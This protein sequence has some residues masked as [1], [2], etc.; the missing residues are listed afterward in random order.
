MERTEVARGLARLQWWKITR[1]K[2]KKDKDRD[3]E[4]PD[5]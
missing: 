5:D 1:K 4:D 3:E 2:L